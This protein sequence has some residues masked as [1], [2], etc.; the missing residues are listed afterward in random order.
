MTEA[1]ERFNRMVDYFTNLY[2]TGSIPYVVQGRPSG[3]DYTN[4]TLIVGKRS[5]YVGASK[6]KFQAYG[7]GIKEFPNIMDNL[8]NIEEMEYDEKHIKIKHS[9]HTLYL[10]LIG[11]N[12]EYSD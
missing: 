10:D 8:D 5:Y 3:L 1:Y 6:T 12:T 2:Y 11:G 7:L 4:M 9:G